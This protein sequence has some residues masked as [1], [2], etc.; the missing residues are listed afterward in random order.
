MVDKAI[1]DRVG[2][3]I[4]RHLYYL[5]IISGPL[6]LMVCMSGRFW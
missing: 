1:F 2:L 6:L 4:F 3:P 5:V